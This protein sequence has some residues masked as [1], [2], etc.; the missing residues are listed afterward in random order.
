MSD[1][2]AK[3]KKGNI[4]ENKHDVS[5]QIKQKQRGEK[6][7]TLPL[8]LLLINNHGSVTLGSLEIWVCVVSHQISNFHGYFVFKMKKLRW[9]KRTSAPTRL[10]LRVVPHKQ[11]Q[12][13]QQLTHPTRE[14]LR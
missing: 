6:V 9:K 4:D 5:F 13:R 10:K 7:N 14:E 2:A 3:Y 11:K 8:V 12:Q 1:D